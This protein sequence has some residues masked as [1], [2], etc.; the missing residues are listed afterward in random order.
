MSFDW[1]EAAGG[2]FGAAGGVFGNI[3]NNKA[4]QQNAQSQ[5]WYNLALQQQSQLWNK[6]MADTQYQ[7]S[8]ADLRAAGLNPI[9]A[10]GGFTPAGGS[11]GGASVSQADSTNPTEGVASSAEQLAKLGPAISQMKEAAKKTE[12]EVKTEKERAKNV[13]ADTTLKKAQLAQTD[14]NTN[15]QWQQ[16]QTE[17]ARTQREQQTAGREKLVGP[18]NLQNAQTYVPGLTM[19]IDAMSKPSTHQPNSA[20]SISM[21]GPFGGLPKTFTSRAGVDPKDEKALRN[22]APR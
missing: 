1:G 10:A 5:F 16:R 11:A 7:R 22:G 3:L 12:A 18:G 19:A 8:V 17:Q 9:L 4:Q 20:K 14:V 13:S 2:I 15:L 21:S 6:Q